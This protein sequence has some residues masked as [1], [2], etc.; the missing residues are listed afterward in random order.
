MPPA[1]STSA[2]DRYINENES[3]LSCDAIRKASPLFRTIPGSKAVVAVLSRLEGGK[4]GTEHNGTA[5]AR[6]PWKPLIRDAAA[7]AGEKE[8]ANLIV[9]KLQ[10]KRPAPPARPPA[11]RAVRP[12]DC[13]PAFLRAYSRLAW[14]L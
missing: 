14:P 2:K 8:P 13:L 9:A 11:A 10:K 5:T 3:L 6:P 12:T 7:T 4:E 1:T